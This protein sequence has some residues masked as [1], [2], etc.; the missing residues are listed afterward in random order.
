MNPKGFT[1]SAHAFCRVCDA[2]EAAT[3]DPTQNPKSP[4]EWVFRLRIPK[5][6]GS[7]TFEGAPHPTA[8]FLCGPCRSRPISDIPLGT[9]GKRW[10]I[11]IT[12]T[13]WMCHCTKDFPAEVG[14]SSIAAWDMNVAAVR[15]DLTKA[16]MKE[17]WRELKDFNGLLFCPTCFQRV[18]T[19]MNE[20]K[21]A[22]NPAHESR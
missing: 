22:L 20:T 19:F 3:V 14:F 8:G 4:T 12:G 6:W 16:P 1:V 21:V 7:F 15:P 17:W 18:C 5:D 11:V 13:C 10:D 9:G 2:R